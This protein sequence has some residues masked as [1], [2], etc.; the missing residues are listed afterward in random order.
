MYRDRTYT[1]TGSEAYYFAEVASIL[2][3]K[4]ASRNRQIVRYQPASIL[5]YFLHLSK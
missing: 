1:L 4:L 2:S 3:Q 5:A